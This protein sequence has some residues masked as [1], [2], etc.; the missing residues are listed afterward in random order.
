MRIKSLGLLIYQ[1][2]VMLTAIELAKYDW[3]EA[4]KFRK[5][6]GKK[7]PELMVEQEKTS[8]LGVMVMILLMVSSVMTN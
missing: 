6:M 5:A 4:D 2:D 3:L 1:D 7:I 8:L